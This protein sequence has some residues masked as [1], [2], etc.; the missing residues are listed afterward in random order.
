[1]TAQAESETLSAELLHITK[2]LNFL[3]EVCQGSVLGS[4]DPTQRLEICDTT[5]AKHIK[6]LT[7]IVKGLNQRYAESSAS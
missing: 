1:M 4:G 2:S 7:A 6:E 3:G 5:L